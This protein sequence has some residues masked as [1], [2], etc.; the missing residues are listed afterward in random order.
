V[1]ASVLPLRSTRPK[2]KPMAAPYEGDTDDSILQR[3]DQSMYRFK[4]AGGKPSSRPR[5]PQ[6]F[7]RPNS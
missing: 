2:S 6:R 1:T 4:R 3:A 5:L 7:V